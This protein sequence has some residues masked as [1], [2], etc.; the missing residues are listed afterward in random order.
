[1]MQLGVSRGSQLL[2]EST[3]TS[4]RHYTLSTTS[5]P[6]AGKRTETFVIPAGTNRMDVRVTVDPRTLD[7]TSVTRIPGHEATP[8]VRVELDADGAWVMNA[9]AGRA[10]HVSPGTAQQNGWVTPTG[11]QGVQAAEKT[12]QQLQQQRQHEERKNKPQPQ[13][14]PKPKKERGWWPFW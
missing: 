6:P 9:A 10:G 8:R 7:V 5:A 12:R 13:N 2:G 14:Q 1:M 3:P 4:I 11:Q